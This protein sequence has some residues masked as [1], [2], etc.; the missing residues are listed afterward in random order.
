MNELVLEVSAFYDISMVRNLRMQITYD[1]L[2]EVLATLAPSENPLEIEA[3]E[4]LD[5]IRNEGQAASFVK[6]SGR[7]EDVDGL[8][9]LIAHRACFMP[10]KCE[11]ISA[12]KLDEGDI[13]FATCEKKSVC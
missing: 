6:L 9:D 4:L 8:L 2:V 10:V 12:Y 3:H 7:G 13:Q 5:Y 1:Q 11:R